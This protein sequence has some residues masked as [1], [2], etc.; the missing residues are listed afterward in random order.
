MP[1][2]AK[3]YGGK[4]TLQVDDTQYMTFQPG[5]FGPFHLSEAKQEEL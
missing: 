2:M 4:Q 5:N 1:K 3:N